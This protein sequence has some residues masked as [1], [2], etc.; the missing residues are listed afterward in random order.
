MSSGIFVRHGDGTMVELNEQPYDSED[1]LQRLLAAH[2]NLLAGDQINSSEPRRW[3]LISR[4]VGIAAEEGGPARWSLDHLFLDQ[5][6]VPTLVEVKRSSDTR[7]RREVIGQMLDYAANAIVYWP[8][9]TIRTTYQ[10]AHQDHEAELANF[11]QGGDVEE[12]WQKAKTN[13]QAGRVRMLFVANVISDE[14][15]RIVEFLNQ[16]MDPAEVLAV[17]IRQ[18]AGPEVQT[19]IPRVFGQ[20]AAAERKKSTQPR[21]QRHWDE[22]MFLAE[23][24]AQQGEGS[25]AAAQK[26]LKWA[27]SRGMRIYWGTGTQDGSFGVQAYHEGGRGRATLATAYTYGSVEIQFQVLKT[28]REFESDDRR[29]ELLNYL[30]SVGFAIPR[31]AIT[32]RP[33]ISLRDLDNATKLEGLL[34]SLAWAA[35]QF[36]S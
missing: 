11:L 31:D 30:N 18:F 20:T 6:A 3:L 29:L 12:F 33:S 22:G 7:L 15:R 17:E 25:A 2:P 5:D 27:Q 10:A 35:D 4:E 28:R 19:F 8:I 16:Q 1:L 34:S 13:L 23:L 32:R 14:L 24:Q 36:K 21:E 26:I 9:E